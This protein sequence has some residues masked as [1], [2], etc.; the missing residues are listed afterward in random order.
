MDAPTPEQ[1][2]ALFTIATADVMRAL[3]L[4]GTDG[5]GGDGGSVVDQHQQLRRCF[6]N[7][8]PEWRQREV[9]GW[10]VL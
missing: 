2:I 9:E 8:R 1:V 10:Q 4:G 7:D 5:H 3:L 6:G